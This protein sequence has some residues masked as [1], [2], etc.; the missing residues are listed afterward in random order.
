M[1]IKV[2]LFLLFHKRPYTLQHEVAVII[3]GLN[4]I[5]TD[6]EKLVVEIYTSQFSCASDLT[7]DSEDIGELFAYDGYNKN[8]AGLYLDNIGIYLC[9]G[10]DQK[11]LQLNTACAFYQYGKNWT[12]IPYRIPSQIAGFGGIYD[13]FQYLD[14]IFF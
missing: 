8:M 3:G 1:V 13:T 14:M 2:F 5:N 10:E 6:S 9:G 11:L 12:R 7:S 4:N